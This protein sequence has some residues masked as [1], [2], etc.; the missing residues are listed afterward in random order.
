MA[1]IRPGGT[2][3]VSAPAHASRLGPSDALV[4]HYRRYDPRE[5]AQLLSKAGLVDVTV[6]LYGGPLGWL[7]EEARNALARRKFAKAE[8][9][10]S[11]D[12]RTAGSGR[13]L[14]PGSGPLAQVLQI[15]LR[16]LLFVQRMFPNRGVALVASG[17]RPAVPA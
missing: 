6:R 11:F 2:L 13:F 17:R 10:A 14:Q 12:E 7:L 8:V 1:R 9:S 5:M 4:G 3:L 15:A 16:P